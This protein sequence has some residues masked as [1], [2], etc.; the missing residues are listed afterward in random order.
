MP[1]QGG[2]EPIKYKR[3]L[4]VRGPSGVMILTAVTA[5]CAYGF[6][7][8]GK[9]NL[10]KR[11]VFTHT[12]VSLSFL[13]YLPSIFVHG[14]VTFSFV[15]LF[16]TRKRLRFRPLVFLNTALNSHFPYLS[17][18]LPRLSRLPPHGGDGSLTPTH[19]YFS[20]I[21]PIMSMTLS[22]AYALDTDISTSL[23]F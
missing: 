22:W 18:T 13:S 2:F 21:I 9:G 20:L 23:Q 10:E 4:P 1:P 8:V 12:P 19:L 14:T 3:N 15:S 11:Y 5:V 6:Y 7:R 17:Y 16:Y